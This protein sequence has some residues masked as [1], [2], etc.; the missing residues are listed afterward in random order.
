MT[1][2]VLFERTSSDLTVVILTLNEEQHIRRCICS[3]KSMARRIVVI[4]CGS[5]D[6]TCEFA[7]DLG[8]EVFVNPFTTHANQFNWGLD[9]ANITTQWVMKLDADE[10]ITQE[11]AEKLPPIL[12]QTPDSIGGFTI[13]LRRLFMGKWLRHGALYP[14]K[15]LRIWRVDRGRLDERIMDEHVI[16]KGQIVHIEADFVD[17]NLNSLTW[18]T[19]KHNKYS[20]REAAALLN[21][22]H[23][24][25][26]HGAAGSL[27]GGQQAFIKRW[28]KERIYARLPG[29]FRAF[30]YFF[31]RYI[32]RLG[33][34]D[35]RAGTA[36][37]LLQGFWYRYLV[38]AKIAEVKRYM[39]EH[40]ADVKLAVERVL[41]VRV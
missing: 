37:H 10:Y 14:I 4:D 32:I 35:G 2:N 33:F 36:F 30:A 21:L 5:L 23:D 25:M 40:D 15:L 13:N 22:E 8:A 11:L 19:D 16:V 27:T 41:G 26:P 31:Y 12:E 34:L 20:S 6:R 3:V 39:C 17:H 28:L 29:G 7:A 9:N 18:W 1:K 38:D 24:F